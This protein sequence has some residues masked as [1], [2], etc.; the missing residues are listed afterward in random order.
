[1]WIPWQAGNIPARELPGS[2]DSM[3]RTQLPAA[4]HRSGSL[5]AFHTTHFV[6]SGQMMDI[7]GNRSRN[8][9]APQA[10]P[11]PS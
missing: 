6:A 3:R 10:P 7:T 11:K 2:G 8:E 1:M 5:G 4:K 9:P